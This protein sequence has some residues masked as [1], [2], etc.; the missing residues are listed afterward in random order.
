MICK[1]KSPEG[2]I[3]VSLLEDIYYEEENGLLHVD[4][5]SS[6][7]LIEIDEEDAMQLLDIVYKTEKIDLSKYDSFFDEEVEC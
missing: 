4:L 2:F 1:Y 7:C 3:A 5:T 6:S